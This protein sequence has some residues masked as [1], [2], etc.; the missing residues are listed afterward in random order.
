MEAGS[1]F[2]ERSNFFKIKRYC[3]E[4]VCVYV[5]ID[6]VIFILYGCK[7]SFKI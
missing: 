7:D 4:S 5:Y 6:V 3:F 2:R 1:F